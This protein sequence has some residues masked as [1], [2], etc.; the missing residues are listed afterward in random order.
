MQDLGVGGGGWGGG[1]GGGMRCATP[2]S[3]KFVS[4][5]ISAR[6]VFI[7]EEERGPPSV[8]CP[9]ALHSNFARVGPG[10]RNSIIVHGDAFFHHDPWPREYSN[11]DT[12]GRIAS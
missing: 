11:G 7:I 10:S 1:G 5:A 12:D 9:Q 4:I 6:H 8:A 2:S 3:I